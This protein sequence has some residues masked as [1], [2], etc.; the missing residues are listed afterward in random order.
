MNC[1]EFQGECSSGVIKNDGELRDL[2]KFEK[3]FHDFVLEEEK[4]ALN[5]HELEVA[6]QEVR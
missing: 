6:F 1:V 4:N 3:W 2:T 5:F